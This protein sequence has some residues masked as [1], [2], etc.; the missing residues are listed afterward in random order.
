LHAAETA[1]STPSN[2]SKTFLPAAVVSS[3]F[4][5]NVVRC[6]CRDVFACMQDDFIRNW[7][8][9][10]VQSITTCNTICQAVN[11]F[12]VFFQSKDKKN[13]AYK[14]IGFFAKRAR[15]LMSA[16]IIKNRINQA[17]EL[18]DFTADGYAYNAELSA[19][20]APVFTRDQ[21]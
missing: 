15:G 9:N 12:L 11:H 16:W 17:D 21:P 5:L 4:I 7:V 6:L 18:L 13:D 3:G 8:N 20:N 14:M 1:L 2:S 19:P 10:F